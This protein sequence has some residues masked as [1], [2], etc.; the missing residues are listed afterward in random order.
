MDLGSA[1]YD[2]SGRLL[3]IMTSLGKDGRDSEVAIIDSAMVSE[4]EKLKAA[5]L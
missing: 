4:I 2:E 1:M 3:G 5:K